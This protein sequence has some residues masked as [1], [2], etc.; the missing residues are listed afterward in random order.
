MRAAICGAGIAG[1]TLAN[2][3]ER[4]GQEA[5]VIERASNAPMGYMNDFFGSG[6]DAAELLGPPVRP[7]R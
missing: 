7:Q 1:P 6:Y 2:C 3:L 4:R 5:I